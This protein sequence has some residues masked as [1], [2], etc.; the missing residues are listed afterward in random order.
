MIKP[1]L[2]AGMRD[3]GPEEVQKRKVIFDTIRAVFEKHG[4]QPIETSSIENLNTLTGKYGD[5]G[6]QL[7]F[8]ILNSGDFLKKVKPEQLENPKASQILSK[9]AEKG[10]RYDLTVPLARFVAM[11][12]NNIRFP[13]K[14]YQIQN[15]WRA[16]R[17]QKG[18]YREFTQCDADVIGSKALHFDANFVLIYQE[19]FQR[20]GLEG[21][22]LK[23]N[24][25]KLLQGIAAAE[26]FEPLFKT[27]T[28]IIDKLDK[29][30]VAGVEQSLVDAGLPEAFI[31]KFKALIAASSK[32]N[33]AFL[34]YLLD[35]W[36]EDE[37]VQSAVADLKEVM[38]LVEKQ[39]EGSDFQLKIDATLARG[40][41][42]YTGIIYEV[43]PPKG[44]KMGSIG[45]GGRYDG[46]TEVFGL[47]DVAG[48][49]IAFG[50]DRIYDVMEQV[51]LFQEVKVAQA[52]VLITYNEAPDILAKSF[53]LLQY[54]RHEGETAEIFHQPKN[55]KKQLAFAAKNQF[56][57]VVIIGEE[58]LANGQYALKNLADGT[59]ESL[60]LNGLLARLKGQ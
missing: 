7:L 48:I 12:S 57:Y 9:I 11:N 53:E 46:L 40:L 45:G 13:F 54:L 49:G 33:Q 21:V 35:T 37:M 60:D 30:G 43:M 6:D 41:D 38:V 32:D 25:R 50:A 4:F 2:P 20:L 44:V 26:G 16:D 42:Y 29:I 3:F 17:P 52:E 24:H 55:L 47:K 8:K 27:F 51:G 5:E 36:G 28:V 22:V 1:S 59:Q 10:L 56:Q 19:V 23:I 39:L 58:E 14:R 31:P 18:R 15:V 34:A